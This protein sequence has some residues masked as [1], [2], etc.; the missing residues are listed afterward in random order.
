MKTCICVLLL[1]LAL[2]S[3][4]SFAYLHPGSLMFPYGPAHKDVT[5]EKVDDGGTP[6]I[7]TSHSF[8]FY[9]EVFR[10]FFINNNGAISFKHPVTEYTPDVF[11]IKKHCMICPFWADVDN[12]D[13]ESGE[14]YY[15]QTSEKAIMDRVDELVNQHFK[16]LNYSCVWALVVT[17]DEVHYHGSESDRTN[18]FQCILASDEKQRSVVIFIYHKIQWTTGTASGGDPKSG[19]G[20]YAAQAGFNTENTYFNMPFSRTDHILNI[21]STSN[22]NKPGVWMFRV[23]AFEAP[24]GCQHKDSFM[25]FGDTMWEDKDCNQKCVCKPDGKVQC[26]NQQCAEGFVCVPLGRNFR[27]QE[28]EEDC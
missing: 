5:T 9:G 19:L 28:N 11:P 1:A 3:V 15:R 24:G 12:E 8:K 2:P 13:A 17:W 20:G 22:I 18:T 6:Q 16:Y 25:N 23:D 27:C 26:V 4:F 21:I 14:I 7:S 10:H